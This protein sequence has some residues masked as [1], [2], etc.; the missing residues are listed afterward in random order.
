MVISPVRVGLRTV[1]L[2]VTR[3]ESRV[4]KTASGRVSARYRLIPLH[5]VYTSASFSV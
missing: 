1:L 5:L 2:T 4:S 3:V